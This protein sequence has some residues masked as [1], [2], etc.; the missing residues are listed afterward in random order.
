MGKVVDPKLK[1]WNTHLLE[2]S[3]EGCLEKR[4][5]NNA[6]QCTLEIRRE[7]ASKIR[8]KSEVVKSDEEAS[9][10]TRRE[11]VTG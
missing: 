5:N 3:L 8:W 11:K 1:P 7:C 9:H 2:E 6:I 4:K 10:S